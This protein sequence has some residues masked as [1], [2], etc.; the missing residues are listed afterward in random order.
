MQ[1][2]CQWSIFGTMGIFMMAYDKGI[3]TAVEVSDC[4]ELLLDK[5]IRLN[6]NLCNKVLH[7]VGLGENQS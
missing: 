2:R 4:L 6:R 5:D 1:R 3:L 7:Y